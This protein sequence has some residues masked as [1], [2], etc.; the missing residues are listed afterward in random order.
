V[1]AEPILELS[2]L[3]KRFG[4]LAAVRDVSISVARGSVHAIIG[5]NGAGKTTLFNLVTGLVRPDAGSVVFHG[6]DVTAM[7]PW[8]R[9]KRGFGRSFQQANLLWALTTLSNVV[10]PTAAAAGETHR[11]AGTIRPATRE[12]AA[13][14]VERVGLG[15]RAGVLASELSHGD[16]RALELAAAVA[17]DSTLL[18]LDEPTAGLS[19]LETRAA[20]ELLKEIADERALTVLFIEHD[21]D[22]VFSVA[23]HVTVLHEGAV[24]AEGPPAEIRANA[25]VRLAYLGEEDEEEE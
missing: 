23:D 15:A 9:V 6:E 24:L 3:S 8:R 13:R 1:S 12:R 7:P 21:M 11:V 2:H 5:P 22:V 25:E 10:L 18:L 17:V 16:Q 14:I 19:P 20:T 4:G